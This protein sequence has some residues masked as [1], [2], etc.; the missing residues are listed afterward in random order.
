MVSILMGLGS[1][2]VF[3]CKCILLCF[4]PRASV[5]KEWTGV[6]GHEASKEKESC[7]RI[8]FATGFA[9]MVVTTPRQN[10]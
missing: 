10:A 2:V 7:Q 4:N 8:E 3:I 5:F 1:R 6:G 9:G